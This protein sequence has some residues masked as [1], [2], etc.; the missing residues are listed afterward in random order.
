[1]DKLVG[2][3]P[4]ISCE[5]VSTQ[6]QGIRYLI[7]TTPDQLNTLKRNLYSY[8]PQGGIK[9]VNEYLP[10][11]LE[12][13]ENFYSKTVKFKLT[14]PFGL[15]LQRQDTLA[16]HDPV[17]YIT[18]QMSKLAPGEMISLQIVLSPTR[19]K[20][21]KTIAYH[22]KE[23]TIFEY[24]SKKEPHFLV[25]ILFG[26]F[27]LAIKLIK[28]VV[29]MG[30]SAVRENMASGADGIRRVQQ[31]E[32]QS[33]LRMNTYKLQR[34]YSPSELEIIQSIQEKIK[35]PLFDSSIRL[36]VIGKDKYEVEARISSMTSS[37]EPFVSP[38]YQE[39]KVSRSIFDFI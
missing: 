32:L 28:E 1:M 9:I 31:Y 33:K 34:E 37:F 17:A 27:S 39:L 10:P 26:V 21:V 6:N 19:S 15:P 8:L 22:I 20:E 24:L 4:T 35:Q 25:K 23:G 11:N 14:K 29:E 13:L 7:R 2:K 12:N 3:K 30:L 38:S 16:E 5:I 36:L 18:G